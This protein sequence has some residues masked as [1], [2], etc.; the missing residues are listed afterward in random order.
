MRSMLQHHTRLETQIKIVIKKFKESTT[1]DDIQDIKFH[2]KRCLATVDAQL[3]GMVNIKID[4]IKK[5]TAKAKENNILHQG[6]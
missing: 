2:Y 5:T 1:L 6:S 3:S 4:S